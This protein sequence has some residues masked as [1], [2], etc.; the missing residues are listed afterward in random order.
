MAGGTVQV[1]AFRLGAKAR[2][3]LAHSHVLHALA[4]I[5]THDPAGAG[6]LR[7]TAL[8]LRAVGHARGRRGH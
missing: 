4:I 6:Y 7:Q 8:T 1:V 2:S 5:K 3:L